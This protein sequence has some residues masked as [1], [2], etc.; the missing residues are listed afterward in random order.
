MGFVW[1]V[2]LFVQ[3][4]AVFDTLAKQAAEA[5]DAKRL[6]ESVALY[7]KALKLKPGWDDGWWNLGSITY[8]QDHY[9]EC[10]PA[11]HKLAAI[12]PDSAPAWTMAALCEFRLNQFDGA[13]A[14]LARV[15]KLSFQEPPELAHAARL[16][17]ALSLIKL[18]TF[19][20]A[21]IV[22]SEATKFDGKSPEIIAAAGIAGL[23]KPWLPAEVPESSRDL[24][25]KLGDAMAAGMERDPKQAI[26][27]FE[28]V[29]NDYPNEPM[30]HFRFGA[31]L[32][33]DQPDRGVE[34][35]KKSLQLDPASVLALENLAAIYLKRED[36]KTALG[37]ANL[38][39]R[40]SPGDFGTHV[41]LG[42]V[43]LAVD[44]PAAAVVELE[45]A[46]RLA[47]DN[48]DARF[49][50]ASAYARVGRKAD[51]ARERA[52]FLRLRKLSEPVQ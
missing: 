43:L 17:Y 37:Y 5:R 35:I 41:T 29:V 16:H 39:A 15:E 47:P 19:E 40:L 22:L 34:E 6:D 36:P 30:V 18:N 20:K 1:I 24:V 2:L 4:P 21:I 45:I 26:A 10:A 3:P 49:N 13:V 52:E 42:R 32:T 46:K 31:F 11:F 33:L 25:F 51:A 8:D 12:H 38:A 50:L 28:V 14:S 44:D 48:P 7:K 9:A 27:K 23:R